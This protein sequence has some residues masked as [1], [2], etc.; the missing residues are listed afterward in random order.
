MLIISDV[1]PC[2]T[3]LLTLALDGLGKDVADARRELAEDVGVDAQGHGGVSVAEAGRDDMDWDSR[4]EQC[5]RAQVTQVMQP[6]VRQRARSLPK[7]AR[8]VKRH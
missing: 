6:G 5:S 4:Q 7:Q 2:Q 8:E 3:D 1:L